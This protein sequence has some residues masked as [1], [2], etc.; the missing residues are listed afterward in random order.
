MKAVGVIG[1]RFALRASAG[2]GGIA[3]VDRARR[4]RTAFSNR[5]PRRS[6]EGL[7]GGGPAGGDCRW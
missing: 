6:A 5:E 4:R 3:G 2:K 1:R 7:W